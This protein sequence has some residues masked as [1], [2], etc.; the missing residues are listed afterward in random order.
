MTEVQGEGGINIALAILAV[1][2]KVSYAQKTGKMDAG[3]TKYNYASETDFLSVL[4]P[5]MVEA[6]LFCKPHNIEHSHDISTVRGEYNGKPTE[7]LQNHVTAVYTFKLVHAPSGEYELIKAV[8]EGVGGDDKSS[9]KAATGAQKYALRQTF[10]V[11]TGDDPDASNAPLNPPSQ[12]KTK[13]APS[14]EHY[15]KPEITDGK[16]NW[17]KYANE[18]CVMWDSA[19][20]FE[21]I[22]KIKTANN[23]LREKLRTEDSVLSD[24]VTAISSKKAASFKAPPAPPPAE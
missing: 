20:N 16:T 7:R 6:K 1:Y 5:A 4:R 15:V 22:K 23:L 10:L 17:V 21:D 24:K 18:L 13:P 9:Y 8:G 14:I 11:E 2:E 19:K 12:P 3:K